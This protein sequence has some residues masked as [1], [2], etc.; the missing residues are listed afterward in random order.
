LLLQFH[1]SHH[2]HGVMMRMMRICTSFLDEKW[3]F[4][5]PLSCKYLIFASSI[6]KKDCKSASLQTVKNSS[7]MLIVQL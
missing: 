4:K 3:I 5:I 7:N 1:H 6:V 2:S